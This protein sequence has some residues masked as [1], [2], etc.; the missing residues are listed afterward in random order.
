[1]R[2]FF[3]KFSIEFVDKNVE[4]AQQGTSSLSSRHFRRNNCC[5]PDEKNLKLTPKV[6][7]TPKISIFYS[8]YVFCQIL[9]DFVTCKVLKG[10]QG[11]G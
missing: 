8:F 1:M 4:N 2:F 5:F 6:T 7:K 10:Q 3:V 11:N 9:T